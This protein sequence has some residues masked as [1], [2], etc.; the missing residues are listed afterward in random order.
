MLLLLLL[1]DGVSLVDLS[2][3]VSVKVRNGLKSR[4]TDV[5]GIWPF[6]RVDPLVN[7][8]MG[9]LVTEFATGA[10]EPVSLPLISLETL[11][12]LQFNTSST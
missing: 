2:F 5:T 7:L 11:A 6:S 12:P 4:G 10:T 8:Q 1:L 3:K 9:G